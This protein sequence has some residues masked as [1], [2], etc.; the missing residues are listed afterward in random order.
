MKINTFTSLFC[1]SFVNTLTGL[2][3][4]YDGSIKWHKDKPALCEVTLGNLRVQV[5]ANSSKLGRLMVEYSS[6]E[7]FDI[8]L[9]E[10]SVMKALELI[11]VKPC[12]SSRQRVLKTERLWVTVYN[13]KMLNEYEG[14]RWFT[15]CGL[16]VNGIEPNSKAKG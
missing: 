4:N 2:H 8:M 6:D 10:R 12:G 5:L 15:E 3:N 7:P 9:F 16:M 13:G 14:Y 1:S 11:K